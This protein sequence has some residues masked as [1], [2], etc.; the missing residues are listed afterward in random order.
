MEHGQVVD[1]EFRPN[2][3]ML[4]RSTKTWIIGELLLAHPVQSVLNLRNG[5]LAHL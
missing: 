2:R 1:I 3:A 4:S 5:T